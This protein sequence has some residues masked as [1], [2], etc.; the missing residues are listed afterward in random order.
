MRIAFIAALLVLGLTAA[1]AYAQPT[2]VDTALTRIVVGSDL[3]GGVAV[4]RSGPDLT[5]SA[6]GFADVE[7]RAGFAPNTH[8][9]T[10]SITKTFVAA[11]I[12]QLV[13]EGRVDLD[14]PVE[15]YLPGR[16]R[17]EGIDANV[18]TVRQLMRHQSGLP[19]YFDADTPPPDDP[20]TGEQ[21]LDMALTRPAQFAPG[22]RMKYTNTNYIVLGL[23]IEKVT[24][25]PVADEI[26]WRI[27]VPLGLFD[28]YFPAP[29]IPGCVRPSRTPTSWSTAV[30]PTS[31]TSTRPRP[32]RRA[33]WS[34]RTRTCRRSSPRSSTA[35]SCRG[36]CWTR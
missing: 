32:V 9:R 12:M 25:R 5:R 3:A 23:L 13:A 8:V 11:T 21:L 31:P 36:R 35:G 17:G 2:A 18:V 33:G 4:V 6:A 24:G 28:T 14:A 7:T 27:L 15:T 34:R 29:A 16:I 22:A 19:E 20:T 10:A 30:A 26:T 1:P